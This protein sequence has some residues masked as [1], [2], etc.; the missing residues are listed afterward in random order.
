MEV[1]RIPEFKEKTSPGAYYQQPAIDGSRPGAIFCQ[2][3][4][5]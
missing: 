1:V 4:R 5:Y 3:I 2:F